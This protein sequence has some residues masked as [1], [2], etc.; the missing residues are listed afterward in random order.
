VVRAL[1]GEV[2]ARLE[3]KL[4]RVREVVEGTLAG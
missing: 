3:S 4:E 2:D 1:G